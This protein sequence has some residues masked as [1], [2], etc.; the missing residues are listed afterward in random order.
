M[1]PSGVTTSYLE[2]SPATGENGAA[3]PTVVLLHG[4]MATAA[5][6]WYGVARALG[7]EYRVLAPDLRGHGRYGARAPRFTA[8]ACAQDVADLL[9]EV[10]GGS[11]IVVG[12]SM[13]GAIAQ[14]LARR[15]PELLSGIVLC[16]TAAK[17][18]ERDWLHPVVRL[19]G[20]VGGT[21]A[22]ALPGLAAAF[23]R[24]RIGRHDA[25]GEAGG[26]H[27]PHWALEERCHSS[28]ACFIEAGADLNGFDSRPWL[29]SLTVPTAV[30]V[31]TT[32]RT[33]EPWRQDILTGLVPGAQRFTV[34]AGHDAAVAH[35]G[36]F[37]PVL[38]RACR[39]LAAPPAGSAQGG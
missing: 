2:A 37:L 25:A 17:F 16:A 19:V 36:I 26:H 28:L 12:Y 30:V 24:H 5:L 39:A 1:L 29:P 7:T 4:W 21:T 15:H 23:L 22:R 3:V 31:T 13:G 27:H 8:E 18:A 9:V 35:M 10:A 20:W 11:V 32:D 14:V 38:E 34:E 33:V 6:N